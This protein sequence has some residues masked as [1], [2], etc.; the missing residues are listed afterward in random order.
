MAGVMGSDRSGGSEQP[1]PPGGIQATP[2]SYFGVHLNMMKSNED[3]VFGI[4]EHYCRS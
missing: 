2:I 3:V 4:K 1:S